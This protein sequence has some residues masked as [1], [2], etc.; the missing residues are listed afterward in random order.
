MRKVMRRLSFA[1]TWTTMG[2]GIGPLLVAF[3]LTSFSAA[4]AESER[5]FDEAKRVVLPGEAAAPIL[6]RRRAGNE[7]N[8]DQ[9]SITLENLDQLE[10]VLILE[11]E[12]VGSGL[13]SFTPHE[14]YRQYMPGRWKG[15]RVIFINGFDKPVSDLFPN[16]GISP[17]Q[18]K[19]ELVTTFGG[20]CA[21]WY[22]VYLVDQ[23]RL[24]ILKKS[25]G[26]RHATLIC[27]GP[28]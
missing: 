13:G 28:K 15:L 19:H 21:Y 1:K 17:D 18:W 10:A 25:D 4:Y 3:V 9:W 26:T 8:T 2:R 24:M 20:G 12:K 22:A 14:S 5:P 23:N 16:R 6:A 27:N 11:M 7:W